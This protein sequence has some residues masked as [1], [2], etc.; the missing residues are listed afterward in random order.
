[1]PIKFRCPKCRQKY[2]VETKD[3]GRKIRCEKCSTKMRVP[4][5]ETPSAETPGAETPGAETPGAEA[6]TEEP[7]ARDEGPD[8]DETS[9][10]FQKPPELQAA[11]NNLLNDDDEDDIFEGVSED[12]GDQDDVE[13]EEAP[14]EDSPPVS[15]FKSASSDDEEDDLAAVL[16]FEES[17]ENE[18]P[19]PVAAPLPDELFAEDEEEEQ[20]FYGGSRAGMDEEMDLTPMVD[21]TFLLLIF[22]MITASFSIQKSLEVPA[23]DPE[24]KGASSAIINPEDIVDESIMVEIDARNLVT[25]D[26]QMVNDLDLLAKVLKSARK[27]EIL[28]TAHEDSLHEVVVRVIDAANEIGLQKIRVGMK[29]GN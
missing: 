20:D 6:A 24:E 3:A 23:P 10:P 17:V 28:I 5:A 22:F 26:E 11:L 16:A 4:S 15:D 13:F 29:R 1:M 21:V 12:G 25:V 19:G 2:S 7:S 18:S 9:R 8:Q 27:P 14:A